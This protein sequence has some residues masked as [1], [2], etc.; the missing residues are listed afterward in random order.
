ML[1]NCGA[2]EDKFIPLDHMKYRI[3]NMVTT[4]LPQVILMDNDILL[5]SICGAICSRADN[6]HTCIGYSSNIANDHT[7]TLYSEVDLMDNSVDNAPMNLIGELYI[8]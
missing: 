1:K 4:E 6:S 3:V 2:D 8:K 5:S 7:C